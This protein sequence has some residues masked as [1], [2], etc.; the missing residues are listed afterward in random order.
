[1]EFW[2]ADEDY[3]GDHCLCRHEDG[4]ITET[5]EEREPDYEL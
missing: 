5:T 3:D 1:M 2:W 4:T